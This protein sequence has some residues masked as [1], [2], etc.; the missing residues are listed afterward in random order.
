MSVSPG[1]ERDHLN[2][3]KRIIRELKRIADAIEDL[4]KDRHS[5]R[6]RDLDGEMED[7]GK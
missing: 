6:T 3:Q 7:D 5:L 4:S 2:N 1:F